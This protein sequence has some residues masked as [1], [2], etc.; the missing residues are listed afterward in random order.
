MT[1][2]L[3][4]ATHWTLDKRI[5]L[6]VV[7]TIVV[8]TAGMVWWAATISSRVAALESSQPGERDRADKLIKLETQQ[9][10]MQKSLENISGKLDRVIE[11]L[12]KAP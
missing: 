11:R 1:D 6:A 7:L 2:T 12:P 8:Q 3:P 9:E 10:G 5:P 4:P